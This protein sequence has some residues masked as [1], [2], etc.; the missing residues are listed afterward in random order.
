MFRNLVMLLLLVPS[1][2]VVWNFLNT[3]KTP[4]FSHSL[5][6]SIIGLVALL[7]SILR[8]MLTTVLCLCLPRI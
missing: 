1:H 5:L 4:R 2:V 7:G 8:L 6:A 3:F